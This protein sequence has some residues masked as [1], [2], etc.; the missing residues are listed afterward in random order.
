MN[1]LR[2]LILIFLLG[3]TISGCTT[4][5]SNS[6]WQFV[7]IQSQPEG[8]KI[9]QGDELLGT[10]PAFVEL[11]RQKNPDSI[12]LDYKNEKKEVELQSQYRWSDSF[13]SDLIFLSA[14]PIAW[15]V[16]LANGT[17]WDIKK[18]DVIPFSAKASSNKRALTIAISPPHAKSF[19]LS[20]IAGK[21]WTEKMKALYPHDHVIPY[22]QTLKEF[23]EAHSAYDGFS[24]KQALYLLYDKL[25][26][27][28][29]L[30]SNAGVENQMLWSDGTVIDV[31]SDEIK[32]EPE[33]EVAKPEKSGR[34]WLTRLAESDKWH[35]IPDTVGFQFVNS[36][37]TL[38][39][40][41]QSF[42]SDDIKDG[43]LSAVVPYLSSVVLT[44][45]TRWDNTDHL[46]FR[47]QFFPAI[48]FTYRH[49][50][51]P[52]Y[53]PISDVDFKFLEISAGEGAE[54]G[55]QYNRHYL[56]LDLV[57]FYSYE[58]LTWSQAGQKHSQNEGDLTNRGEF[59]YMYS[60]NHDF[61]IRFFTRIDSTSEGGVWSKAVNDI[62]PGAGAVIS[63]E[64][65]YGFGLNYTFF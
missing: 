43:S 26:V 8:A 22:E 19:E 1:Q 39:I 42:Y 24:D 32:A 62:H 23:N 36:N 47:W 55:F 29:V 65:A 48:S 40:N 59:G 21:M 27:D 6:H 33:F 10:T 20:D 52:N 53:T 13:A 45:L 30:Q 7:P 58:D 61:S 37:L 9:Y 18:P 38:K 31:Y 35:V 11:H 28:L 41:D 3:L 5:G 16:D 34:F 56:Y 51:F 57:L 25:K 54:V 46:K 49:V 44:R 64:V 17:A 14:A 2:R 12:T 15:G 63:S 50:N 60:F 4:M